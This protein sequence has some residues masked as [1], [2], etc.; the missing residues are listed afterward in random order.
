ML[1]IREARDSDVD[2]LR[3]LFARVY[4]ED[5]PFPGFY[6]TEWLKKSVYDDNTIFL[7]AE[8]DNDIIA[9]GSMML[10]T[11]GLDDLI[12]ELGRLV[13]APSRA[14]AGAAAELVE[15]LLKKIRRRV[16]FAFGEVRTFHPGSQRIAEKF[17]WKPV[18]FEPMKYQFARRESVAMYADLQELAVEL[19][20]NN[21]RVIPECALLAQTV[22]KSLNLPVDVI[23]E[24]ENEGYPTGRAF[25]VQRLAETG[26]TPLLRIERGR[27]SSREIFGHF[28]L[29]HGFFR[30]SNSQSH[31]LV[32]R[33]GAAVLGAVGFT[34]DTIDRKVRIFELIEFDNAVKGYLLA[35]VDRIARE[36]FNVEYQEVD[37][38]AYSPK[39][40]RTFER[41]GFVPVAYCPSMVFDNV[42]RLDV[43]RMAKISCAYDL[44]KLRLLEG[45]ERMKE[46]VEQALEDRLVGME[47]TAG[48]R[49]AEIFNHLPDG[50]LFH[51][52]RIAVLREYDSGTT[53]IREGGN[54]DCLYILVEG[55]A[56]AR[57]GG[58]L[59]AK[60]GEGKIF[61]EMGLVEQ[62]KRSADV[63]ISQ[64][65]KVIEIQIPRLV[66]L[67][68]LHPRLGFIVMQNLAR[69]LS[70]K[71][72]NR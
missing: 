7:V 29:S 31:Y 10:D 13:A 72:R 49:K 67:M 19:R 27:I 56:E 28:S 15:L 11:G 6:D 45:A 14:A 53:L 57:S 52:A 1:E 12:G 4:G 25:E 70:E 35:S 38:S 60:L 16:Q 33:D 65:S 47:I 51:L 32:A 30:I 36:E 64:P 42:E 43:I 44:G 20:R 46:I 2:R 17:G 54:A 23:V 34:H 9:T 24:D 41:L 55:E 50:D 5:Y 39:I 71:L 61:G 48:T 22:L 69:G 8:K 26:V 58:N 40:Q 59:L 63:V 3:D 66:R 37:V 62:T 68:E 18:G 21:P